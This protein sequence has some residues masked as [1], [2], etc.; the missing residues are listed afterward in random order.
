MEPLDDRGRVGKGVIVQTRE[1]EYQFMKMKS[2][3]CKN[4]NQVSRDLVSIF[5]DNI[6]RFQNPK[7]IERG[8]S[9]WVRFGNQIEIS[10]W[11]SEILR[12]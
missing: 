5:P 10:A 11:K 6:V 9:P 4:R 8:S 12:K 1:N 3:F 2:T 7:S